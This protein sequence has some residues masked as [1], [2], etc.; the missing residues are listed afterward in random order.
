LNA[1]ELKEVTASLKQTLEARRGE[2]FP[3]QDDKGKSRGDD[4]YW[5]PAFSDPNDPE[6]GL[7]FD[8]RTEIGREMIAVSKAIDEGRD[9]YADRCAREKAQ[10]EA[11]RAEQERRQDVDT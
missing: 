8:P 10:R 5:E 7:G 1:R 9:L 11:E 2:D 3:E 6:I 4:I